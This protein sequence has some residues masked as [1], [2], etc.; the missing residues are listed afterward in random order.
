[1]HVQNGGDTRFLDLMAVL[2]QV[3]CCHHTLATLTPLNALIKMVRLSLENVELFQLGLEIAAE[4]S[5]DPTSPMKEFA[6]VGCMFLVM[7]DN[8]G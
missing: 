1:M 3:H 6:E 5:D 4:L 7:D 8:I 2:R